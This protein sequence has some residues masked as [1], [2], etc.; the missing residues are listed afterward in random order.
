MS[1]KDSVLNSV[2]YAN[3]EDQVT[4]GGSEFKGRLYRFIIDSG[5]FNKLKVVIP[6][7]MLLYYKGKNNKSKPE[8]HVSASNISSEN[9]MISKFS[10][11][12]RSIEKVKVLEI[13]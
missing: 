5:D 10:S 8:K 13:Q 7:K 9:A 1:G 2:S 11:L 6:N 12:A 3:M 4:L